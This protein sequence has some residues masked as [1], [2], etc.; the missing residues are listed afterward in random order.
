MYTRL[1]QVCEGCGQKFRLLS[2]DMRKVR[3]MEQ[4]TT[5]PKADTKFYF[6]LAIAVLALLVGAIGLIVSLTRPSNSAV[7]PNTPGQSQGFS[8]PGG[9]GGQPIDTVMPNT[10]NGT[11]GYERGVLQN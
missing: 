5:P 4:H 3:R 10:G 11:G 9:S 2:G 1:G 7:T 6:V 8:Q